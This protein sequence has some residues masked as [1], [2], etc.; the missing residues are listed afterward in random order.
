VK[1]LSPRLFIFV[2]FILFV[3][4]SD[5]QEACEKAS[6]EPIVLGA[7]FPQDVLLLSD[8]SEWWR[9]TQAMTAAINDC[10]GVN[11]RPVEYQ[12]QEAATEE[13]A[14]SAFES[15]QVESLP[16]VVA[17]GFAPV[18]EGLMQAAENAGVVLW[19]VTERPTTSTNSWTFYAQPSE[20][21]I[22]MELAN[23]VQS[24]LIPQ[25]GIAE[26]RLALISEERP[27]ATAIAEG[28]RDTLPFTP[29]I[30]VSYENRLSESY[31]L[32]VEMRETEINIVVVLSFSNDADRLWEAMQQA[33]ANVA[34]W[35][36]L[37]GDDYR[38][39]LDNRI[40][41]SEGMLLVGAN[42]IPTDS[43][44]QWIAPEIYEAYLEHYEDLFGEAPNKESN[45]SAIGV[46]ILLREILPHVAEENLNAAGIRAIMEARPRALWWES[47]EPALLVEQNQDGDFCILAPSLYA[48]C[49]E[50]LQAFP[51]WRQRVLNG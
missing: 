6:G 23:Y 30:D 44:A 13:E 2:L 33:D 1:K 10:G 14:L 32:S 18:H 35:L 50:G 20:R 4:P 7:I 17:S 19:E 41:N 11:G 26:A 21:E 3:F 34:A 38:K 12:F 42:G 36:H 27:R 29:M 43:F 37:G 24:Q 31:P 48:S 25:I 46:Y 9:G 22:G 40:G 8:T 47:S 49:D 51:T 16:L 28:F 39:S 45:L 15:L 5:A